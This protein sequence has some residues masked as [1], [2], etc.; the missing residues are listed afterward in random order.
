[1]PKEFA[2]AAASSPCGSS[3]PD[4]RV[5]PLRRSPRVISTAR[6]V[7]KVT[8][9]TTVIGLPCPGNQC[10]GVNRC[11]CVRRDRPNSLL[12]RGPVGI[13]RAIMAIVRRRFTCQRRSVMPTVR[14]ATSVRHDLAGTPCGSSSAHGVVLPRVVVRGDVYRSARTFS[15]GRRVSGLRTL[16]VGAQGAAASTGAHVITTDMI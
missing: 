3:T 2:A 10:Y 8:A 6:P 16:A 1:M 12:Y 15:S 7:R 4:R 5:C 13:G 14:F 9:D 11:K